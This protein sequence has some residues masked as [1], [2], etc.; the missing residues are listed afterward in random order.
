MRRKLLGAL[1]LIALLSIA[2]LVWQRFDPD[3][4]ASK[5]YLLTEPSVRVRFGDIKSAQLKKYVSVGATPDRES[6]RE[7]QWYVS[8]SKTSGVVKVIARSQEEDK[9]SRYSV[10]PN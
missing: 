5:E 6:Y 1:S 4:Q 7:Y 3:V 2:F 8:G 9:S 10:A